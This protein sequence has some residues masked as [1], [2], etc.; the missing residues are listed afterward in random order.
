[1]SDMKECSTCGNP[2]DD[3]GLSTMDTRWCS[4]ICEE[5]HG[6]ESCDGGC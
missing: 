1:M 4:F 6:C 2:V 5:C 3:D